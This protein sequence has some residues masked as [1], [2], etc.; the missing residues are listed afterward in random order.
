MEHV[1]VSSTD[2]DCITDVYREVRSCLDGAE[3]S[4]VAEHVIDSN[5]S[6]VIFNTDLFEETVRKELFGLLAELDAAQFEV[7]IVHHFEPKK[8]NRKR[9]K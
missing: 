3:T 6:F 2:L 9:K 8:I 7:G 4:Q 1:I 5:F